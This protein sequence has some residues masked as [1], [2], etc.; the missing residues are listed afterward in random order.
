MVLHKG[1]KMKL[2]IP[3]GASP[4][5]RD[6][7]KPPRPDAWET[8]GSAE[9]PVLMSPPTKETGQRST[10]DQEE[11]KRTSVNA[12]IVGISFTVQV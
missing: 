4:V 5:C 2:T 6:P 10:R 9:V 12:L 1:R 11:G 3:P 7:A 8:A